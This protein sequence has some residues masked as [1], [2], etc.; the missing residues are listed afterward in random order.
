MSTYVIVGGRV[1]RDGVDLTPAE[2]YRLLQEVE[3]LPT[4]SQPSVGDFPYH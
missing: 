2:F 3:K 4:T 1:F